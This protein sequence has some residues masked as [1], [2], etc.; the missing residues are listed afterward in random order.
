MDTDLDGMA[1]VWEMEYF[2]DLS[3]DGSVD[4]D[5]DGFADLEEYDN[6]DDGYLPTV[7]NSSPADCGLDVN[8]GAQLTIHAEATDN[9]GI[10]SVTFYGNGEGL[11]VDTDLPFEV[12]VTIPVD[13]SIFEIE[14]VAEDLFGKTN[15]DMCSLGVVP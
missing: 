14:A 3:H 8:E 10:A 1:D 6:G 9:T 15:S 2:G 5:G 4:S 7:S 11:Y 13:I 12:D